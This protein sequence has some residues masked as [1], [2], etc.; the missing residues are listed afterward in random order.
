MASPPAYPFR[1]RSRPA[2]V[3][4][5][6]A[7][8][9]DPD[10]PG[11]SRLDAY[12]ASRAG[13]SRTPSRLA[14]R[15]RPVWQYQ[16]VPSLSGLL[17]PSPASPGSGCPQL[18]QAAATTQRPG[19]ST[20][21]RHTGASWRTNRSSNRRPGSAAAQWCSLAC[22]RRTRCSAVNKPGQ[23]SGSPVFTS[24]SNPCSSSLASTRWAPSPCTRLSRARTTTG[25]PPHPVA[26]SRRR[27]FPPAP[28]G[29]RAGTGTTGGSHVHHEPINRLAGQLCPSS[30]A[31]ATP[32]AFTVASRPAI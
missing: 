8:Q 18:R 15:T 28:P 19:P 17:P 24:A 22:I 11:S 3:H 2:T 9:T 27:A 14:C 25:P 30:I 6:R 4:A 29:R 26:V 5:G 20:P 7:R 13:S 21:A 12:G 10:P 32:Q 16:G 1:L 23:T 31:T